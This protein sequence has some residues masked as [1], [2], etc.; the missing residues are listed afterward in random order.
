MAGEFEE[1]VFGKQVVKSI[2][3]SEGDEMDEDDEKHVRK[4]T[5]EKT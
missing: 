2:P 4:Y 5:R 1:M 3:E